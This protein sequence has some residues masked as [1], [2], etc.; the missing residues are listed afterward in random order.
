MNFG[1]FHTTL[2]KKNLNLVSYK[3]FNFKP[4]FN[5]NVFIGG[6]I[7]ALLVKFVHFA[8]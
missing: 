6:C 7:P 4:F 8:A 5:L 1:V 2:P 3:M